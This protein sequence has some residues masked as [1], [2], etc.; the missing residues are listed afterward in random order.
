MRTL[1]TKGEVRC[2]D[3]LRG[4]IELM[5]FYSGPSGSGGNDDLDASIV[6]GFD[7]HFPRG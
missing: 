4:K 5:R 6:A 3:D 1:I 2:L 7:R